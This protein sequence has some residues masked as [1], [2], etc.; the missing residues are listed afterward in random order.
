MSLKHYLYGQGPHWHPFAHRDVDPST[1][2]QVAHEVLHRIDD[3][4][5]PT[6]PYL[7]DGVRC[8]LDVAD[9]WGVYGVGA[10]A[11]EYRGESFFRHQLLLDPAWLDRDMRRLGSRSPVLTSDEAEWAAH[12][13]S[14]TLG[15]EVPHGTVLRATLPPSPNAVTSG[16]VTNWSAAGA[17]TPLTGRVGAPITYADN[18]GRSTPGFL[19]AGH[20]V[21]DPL[22]T[23]NVDQPGGPVRLTIFKSEVPRGIGTS[24]AATLRGA[25]DGAILDATGVPTG[26][27]GPQGGAGHTAPVSRVTTGSAGSGHVVGYA[28]WVATTGSSWCDCYMVSS[29]RGAF[30]EPGHSGAAV[31]SG[32][33]VIGTVV[34][35]AGTVAGCPSSISYVQDIDSVC[36]EFGCVLT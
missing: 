35:A 14:T 6:S 15:I 30:S 18:H 22:G 3:R 2:D 36:A 4:P 26:S 34:G 13:L 9:G 31:T 8:V 12:A 29:P 5:D 10:T 16:D 7:P 25:I 23:V 11:L 20:V 27:L 21:P 1:V 33:V 19:T 24:R 32:A 17:S 28:A